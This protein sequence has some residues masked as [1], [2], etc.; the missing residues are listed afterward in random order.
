MH[1]QVDERIKFYEESG[2]P[3]KKNI[4]VMKSVLDEIQPAVL[5]DGDS[6]QKSTDKKRK[7]TEVIAETP[8]KKK[9]KN[10]DETPSKKKSKSE[11]ETPSKKKNIVPSESPKKTP[12][13][14][15]KK[16]SK[17]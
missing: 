10:E 5:V 12:K 7:K 16:K 17:D 15:K 8:S 3:P 9:S 11:V 14:D 1:N 6:V 4:D 13:S 2:K